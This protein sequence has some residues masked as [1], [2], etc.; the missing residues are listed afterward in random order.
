MNLS[1]APSPSRERGTKARRTSAW[2]YS[3]TFLLLG[4]MGTF[5]SNGS[6]GVAARLPEPLQEIS[7]TALHGRIYVVG[8]INTK[9]EATKVVYRY[10]PA[11]DRWERLNDFPD[12]RHHMPLVVLNDTLFAIG[13]YSPPGFTP[14]RMVLAYDESHDAWL[15]RAFLPE[16]RG[17]SAAAVVDGKIVVVGGVGMENRH[18]DSIAIYDPATDSWRHA[19]PIPTLRD[20]LTAG[21][22]GGI[23]YAIGGRKGQNF[24]VVEAYNPRTD[25]WATRAKMPSERGGLASVVVNDQIYT[26]G[27]ERPSHQGDAGVF[28]NHEQYTPKTDRWMALP[29]L[30]T[31]RHGIGV[32]TLGGRIYVI[33]GGP[34][35]GFAQTDVVEVFTP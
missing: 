8:G 22:V 16:A 19:A 24:D 18:V 25:R 5:S 13:G 26:Y 6:W 21:A 32:A 33:G 35:A 1:P 30:P 9:N 14:V 15:G 11:T 17:A 28:P 3:A 7:A 27:G 31:P 10:D 23:V 34:K 29:P 2:K 4:S 12:Y 20:H